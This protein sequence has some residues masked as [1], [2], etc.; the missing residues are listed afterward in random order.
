[1]KLIHIYAV[2]LILKSGGMGMQP[3]KANTQLQAKQRCRK[4][5]T[6]CQIL[7][8]ERIDTSH[9]HYHHFKSHAV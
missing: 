3:V 2:R 1:M 8:A 7:D 4:R 9:K 5:F 6:K